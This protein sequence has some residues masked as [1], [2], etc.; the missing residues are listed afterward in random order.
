MEV[1]YSKFRIRVEVDRIRHAKKL[2]PNFN[3]KKL[4]PN[5][6]LKKQPYILIFDDKI[7]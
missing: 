3:K 1:L 5:A 6:D 2:D 7:R 4:G